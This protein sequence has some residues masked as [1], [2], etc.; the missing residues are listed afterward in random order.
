MPIAQK[1]KQT[2]SHQAGTGHAARVGRPFFEVF[3]IH[4][5]IEDEV[6]HWLEIGVILFSIKCL[7]QQDRKLEINALIAQI[8]GMSPQLFA[9][10]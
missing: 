9:S 6:A 2:T 8:P 3:I 5:P 10:M 4:D 7:D 1:E